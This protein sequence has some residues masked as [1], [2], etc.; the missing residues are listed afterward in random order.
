[1][2]AL[3]LKEITEQVKQVARQA[4]CFIREQRLSFHTDRVETKGAH[5][6]VSYV[7]KETERMVVESLRDIVPE[8]GF[9]TEEKTTAT[10]LQH[11][12]TWVV[13]PLDGTTNFIHNVPLY[14]VCIALRC[15]EEILLGAV[16]EVTRGELFWAYKGGG[17]WLDDKPIRVSDTPFNQ[18]LVVI[19][20]PYNTQAWTKFSQQ[21]VDRLYGTVANVRSLGSAEGELCYVAAGR[22]DI[23]IE[24]FLSPWDVAA[25]AIILKEAGGTITDYQNEDRLWPSGRQVLATNGR[26]HRQMLETLQPLLEDR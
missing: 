23:Y 16:Y 8:A 2:K 13:D 5:D 24:S 21:L 3:D 18:A 4:G 25:G 20:F 14:C 22:L 10:D 15:R 7:D 6:Y 17:A 26:L 19:G 1:M 11:D 12:Y 9:L